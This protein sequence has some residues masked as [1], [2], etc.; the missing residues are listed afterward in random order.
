MSLAFPYSRICWRCE[1]QQLVSV[2]C[3]A[4]HKSSSLRHHW[5]KLNSEV[6]LDVT[7]PPRA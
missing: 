7:M 4:I 3:T 1:L 2:D 5:A 6:Q